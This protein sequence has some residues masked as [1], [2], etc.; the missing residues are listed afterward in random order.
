MSSLQSRLGAD[1]LR[2]LE[3]GNWLIEGCSD[4]HTCRRID[5]NFMDVENGSF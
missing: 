5:A 4:S 1:T 2:K 3:I